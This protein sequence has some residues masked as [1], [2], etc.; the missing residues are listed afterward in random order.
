MKQ[1]IIFITLYSTLAFSQQEASVWYF[2]QNAGLKFENNTSVTA[3]NDGLLVTEEGCSSIADSNGNLLFY[4]DGRTVWDRNHVK[5]PNADYL[6]GT[7]MFG[8]PS[9]TQSG[10]IVPKPNDPNIYY[11]FTVDEPHHENAAVYPNAFS[12][13]YNTPGDGATPADDDGL[14]N[15]FNYSIVDLSVIG[16]NGSIGDVISRNNHLVTYS[17]NP[18][19]EEIKYKCSEKITAVKNE[20]TN[21]YW[22]ITHFIDT[23]YSFKITSSGVIPTPVTS[24]V[25]A[26]F[27]TNGYRRNALGYLKASPDGEKLA[28]AHNQNGTVPGQAITSTGKIILYNFDKST[29]MVS[30]ENILLSAIQPYGVE[31]SPQNKKLYATY[32]NGVVANMTLAQ[33][34]LLSTN[35]PNSRI[36]IFDNFN[37]LFALQLAPN[38]K[39]Y[40]ATGYE[41]YLGVIN[42]PD[43]NG[44]S[45][46]YVN[47]G[48]TL[49]TNKKVKLG[50]PPFIT[51]FF[52]VGIVCEKLCFGNNTEFS[53]NTNQSIV[54]ILWDFG[55]GSTSNAINP[56]HQYTTS[57]TYNVTVTVTTATQTISRSKSITISQ[58]PIIAAAIANQT[59]CGSNGMSYNLSQFDSVV[60][61]SQSAV[62]YGVAYF[63]S[64]LNATN[65]SNVLNN[66]YN[67]ALG[68]TT[69]YA[70]VFNKNNTSCNTITNFDITLYLQPIANTVNSIFVCDD[71]SNDGVTNFNL[72]NLNPSILG[73]QPASDYSISYHLNQADADSNSNALA[74]N[75]QNISNPQTIY[76]RIENNL[77][78]NCYAT[79][80]FQIGVNKMPI[81]NSLQD[82]YTC[83]D[84]SNDGVE[85]FNLGLQT[86]LLLGSQLPSEFNVSYHLSQS[87]A[88][89]NTFPLLL[90]YQNINNPQTIFVRIENTINPSCYATTSFQLKVMPKPNLVMDATYTIC[91]GV[92]I[93]I[94]AP[95]GFST[96]NWS[97]GSSL[98]TTTI[99]QAGTYTLTVTQNYG[100]II[101]NDSETITVL[102][103]NV[104]TITQIETVDWTDTENSIGVVVTGDGDYEYS[105]DGLSYQDSPNFYGLISG[106]YTVFV[107]DKKG[108]G[109]SNETVYLLMYPKFFTPNSD[110]ANDKWRI[111]NSSVEPNMQLFIYDRYG[112][113]LKQLSSL[114]EGWDGIHN[115]IQMPADDYW[116]VVKRENGKEYRGHFCLKR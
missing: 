27:S 116:F 89:T 67:L 84:S 87:E 6:A 18:N 54:S 52:N 61:G 78:V 49:G 10:I 70:K 29:G 16:S 94:E 105:L 60:L 81:A 37:Y 95:L 13:T 19:G 46:N 93:N 39:I 101:C 102:N 28:I 64:I 107:R 91:E 43:A 33:F 3:L 15:G 58:A 106:E 76:V 32:R 72:S 71:V 88:D 47:N 51:S 34:D 115:G 68:T 21:E 79:T 80:S 12:G 86:P 41:N 7:G 82:L 66:N 26:S 2:G 55:D 38:N 110:G 24:Q 53:V 113:L 92:P 108:C 75:Y 85:T 77:N 11:I 62:D 114:G 8:D 50:L 20:V 35:I 56:V 83:D 59:V 57:G 30:N 63:S 40:C 44:L 100:T 4:T 14:N 69:I 22:V 65:H 73:S 1:L 23:F 111:K 31:F 104:A 48:Q 17:T 98:N 36:T 112:K 9:S 109:V 97:T 74:F 25:G 103:S 96:Y 45:C 42:D 5:M 90:N 99:N